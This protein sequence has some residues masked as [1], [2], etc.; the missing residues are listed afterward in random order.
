MLNFSDC[1]FPKGLWLP[2]GSNLTN[3]AE[4]TKAPCRLNPLRHMVRKSS[5][6]YS[7][8]IDVGGGVQYLVGFLCTAVQIVPEHLCTAAPTSPFSLVVLIH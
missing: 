5:R 8:E 6:L 2:V 1:S 3:P 7:G 4:T